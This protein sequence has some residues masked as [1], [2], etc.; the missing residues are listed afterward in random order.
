MDDK[1]FLKEV[2]S[3]AHNHFKAPIISRIAETKVVKFF[4]Q[5][6]SVRN[7]II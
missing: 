5:M 1:S 6:S 3:R 2:W 7:I 4:K